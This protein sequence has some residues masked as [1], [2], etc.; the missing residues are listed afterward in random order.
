MADFEGNLVCR[1]R[2]N[3]VRP[4]DPGRSGTLRRA[5]RLCFDDSPILGNW[6]AILRVPRDASRNDQQ[7]RRI[8]SGCGEPDHLPDDVP[9]RNLLPCYSDA[10]VSTECCSRAAVVLLDRWAEPSNDLQ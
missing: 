8:S 10:N 1:P 9:L 6:P 5:S 4:N 7:E 2:D 3:L